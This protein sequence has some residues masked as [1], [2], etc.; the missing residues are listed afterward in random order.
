[1][2]YFPTPEKIFILNLPAAAKLLFEQTHHIKVDQSGAK[3]MEK[4]WAL[5]RVLQPFLLLLPA[6]R[7]VS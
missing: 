3:G 4:I 7:I 2:T 5:V 1:M 6:P